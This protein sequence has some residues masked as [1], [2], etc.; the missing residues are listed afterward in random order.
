MKRGDIVLVALQGD[1]GKPR[2][3]VVVQS[4]RFNDTHTSFL[5]C[6][7][8]S[9]LLDMRIVRLRVNPTEFNGL[10]LPS[11]ITVDKLYTVKR[12]K[13]G[14]VVGRLDDQT[15]SDLDEVLAIFIGLTD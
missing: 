8:T 3:A 15:L 7:I 14:R 13:M 10:R 11:Q 2:P 1:Y 5:V 9:S 6:L 12:E 4:D